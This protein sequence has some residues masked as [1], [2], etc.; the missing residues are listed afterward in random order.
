MFVGLHDGVEARLVSRVTDRPLAS[1]GECQGVTSAHPAGAVT[2]LL[3]AVRAVGS[4]GYQL[5]LVRN[6][7]AQVVVQVW[8]ESSR[9]ECSILRRY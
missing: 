9:L 5:E 7:L 6:R 4:A 1:I 3:V 2:L 8:D